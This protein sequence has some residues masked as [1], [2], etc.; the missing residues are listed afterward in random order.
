MNEYIADLEADNPVMIVIH[1]FPA[2]RQLK[3]FIADNNYE[4]VF[5]SGKYIIYAQAV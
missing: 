2:E 5:T 1:G 3:E 4:T